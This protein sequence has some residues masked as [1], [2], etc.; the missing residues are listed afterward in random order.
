MVSTITVPTGR[1]YGSYVR[2]VRTGLKVKLNLSHAPDAAYLAV[3]ELCV[4]YAVD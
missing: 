1:T 3:D 4:V 2:L